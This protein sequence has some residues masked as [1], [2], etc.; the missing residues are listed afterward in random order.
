[1]KNQ[2]MAY[3]VYGIYGQR[4]KDRTEPFINKI[5]NINKAS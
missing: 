1:M 3:N 4:R 2:K 5:K